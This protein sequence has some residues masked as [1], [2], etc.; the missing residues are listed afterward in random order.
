MREAEQQENLARL[1]DYQLLEELGRGATGVVYKARHV[2]LERLVAIKILAKGLLGHD[3]AMRFQREL[4]AL[5]SLDHENIVRATDARVVDGKHILVMDYV[6]GESLDAAVQ[7]HGRLPA[8]LAIRCAIQAARGL[9]YIHQQGIVHRDIKPANLLLGEDGIVRILDLGLARLRESSEVIEQAENIT[10]TRHVLGTMHYISPEQAERSHD[11]DQRTDIYSLGCTLYHLLAGQ[12]PYAGRSPLACLLAHVEQPIPS[13]CAARP[14]IAA[15]L[16]VVLRRMMAK[17]VEDRYPSASEVIAALESVLSVT[18]DG[19]EPTLSMAVPRE[20]TTSRRELWR[21]RWLSAG[22]LLA[23][24]L[25]GFAV[26]SHVLWF[27]QTSDPPG[28][29]E[30][31]ERRGPDPPADPPETGSEFPAS[32]VLPSEA[33]RVRVDGP[34]GLQYLESASFPVDWHDDDAFAEI[35]GPSDWV[36]YP[37][38]PASSYVCEIE[39]TSRNPSSRLE[40]RFGSHHASFLV[41]CGSKFGDGEDYLADRNLPHLR[42]RLLTFRGSDADAGTHQDASLGVRHVL[43]IVVA[44]HLVGVWLNDS[45]F[46]ATWRSAGDLSFAMKAFGPVDATIHRCSFRS[47]FEEDVRR[48]GVALPRTHREFDVAATAK[49]L[50]EERRNLGEV[51]VQGESF[52]VGTTGAV[53]NWIAP[54]EFSMGWAQAPGP[55]EGKGQQPVL[56]SDGYWLGRHQVTQREWELLADSHD[57]MVRGS[58]FLPVHWISWLEAMQYCQRLTQQERAAGRIPVGYEYRLPTEAEWEYACRRGLA[59]PEMDAALFEPSAPWPIFQLREVGNREPNSAGLFD[60]LTGFPEWCADA[61]QAYPSADDRPVAVNRFVFGVSLP[62]QVVTRGAGQSLSAEVI[63]PFLRWPTDPRTRSYYGFRLALGKQL[64]IDQI[65]HA[66]AVQTL[67]SKGRI[68]PIRTPGPSDRDVADWALAIGGSIG[69]AV[70]ERPTIIISDRTALPDEPFRLLEIH[71]GDNLRFGEDPLARLLHLQ[72]LRALH[73]QGTPVLDADL[74]WLEHLNSLEVLNL[75]RTRVSDSGLTVLSRLQSLASLNLAATRVTDAGLVHLTGLPALTSLDL[76]RT[77]VSDGGLNALHAK[78][79]LQ[80]LDLRHTQVSS[81]GAESLG[82]QLPKCR[83]LHDPASPGYALRMLGSSYVTIPTLRVL[84]GHPLTVEAIAMIEGMGW[85]N[86]LVSNEYH[87]GFSLGLHRERARIF[88]ADHRR[89]EPARPPW[90]HTGRGVIDV[91]SSVHI[92]G[93]YEPSEIR[94]YVN[95]KQ[96]GSIPLIGEHVPSPF[97]C[98]IGGKPDGIASTRPSFRGIIDAVRISDVAR[99]REDF[100]PQRR[101]EPDGH[102][103][104]LYHFD[105]GGGEIAHDSS[106]NAHHGRIVNPRWIDAGVLDLAPVCYSQLDAQPWATWEPARV[107]LPSGRETSE[108]ERAKRFRKLDEGGI[109]MDNCGITAPVLAGNVAVRVN[110]E[111]LGDAHRFLRPGVF[112]EIDQAGRGRYRCWFVSSS[113]FRIERQ[114][115]G[116]TWA[117]VMHSQSPPVSGEF[118]FALIADRHRLTGFADGRPVIQI[119]APAESEGETTVA[120]GVADGQARFRQMEYRLT[121]R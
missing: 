113:I 52:Q 29:A 50:A 39:F 77:L 107:I 84:D 44:D 4:L 32:D 16:D 102:T 120:C 40:F 38:I 1:G 63:R 93:V 72:H 87:A 74:R 15:H 101:F 34:G 114:E 94:M 25:V 117:Q 12:P 88:Y 2:H 111:L 81:R 89:K 33:G 73:L 41:A 82:D 10:A 99:Y 31:L 98:I 83:I 36:E 30:V 21:V 91:G 7:R 61:W 43:R 66:A 69:V 13:I 17:A 97:A 67:P 45:F 121:D 19:L 56:F 90:F 80:D 5:G 108:A 47:L 8:D 9:E 24:F 109:R 112:L 57:S 58:P 62:S 106:G 119:H 6:E 70:S 104:A 92:A 59:E 18:G 46:S 14:G 79:H 49:R 100:E 35:R 53:M 78:P 75:A 20:G 28:N 23:F 85:F 27:G 51:P 110:V 60:M 105:E 54:G 48:M 118:T 55:T 3:S 115:A 22:C 95:G 71:L 64:G 103:L 68:I 76:S 11:V 37:T 86:Q 96:E 116:K 26:L 65:V 42:L